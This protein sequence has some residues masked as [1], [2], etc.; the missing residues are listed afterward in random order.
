MPN[1]DDDVYT[2]ATLLARKI[3]PNEDDDV[4]T[5]AT[6][7]ARKVPI[8]DYEI[9]EMNNKPY[10]KISRA[11]ARCTCSNLEELKNYTWLSKGQELEAIGIMWCAYHN[12]Y[13]HTA[14]F[15]SGKKVPTLKFYSKP[16][17]ECCKTSSRR[18]E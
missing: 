13:N 5:E 2:E 10:Y 1:E 16:D 7:L 6:L 15:D 11:D 8:V 3:V 9:I 12:F 18:G 14:D 4:Y 17:A